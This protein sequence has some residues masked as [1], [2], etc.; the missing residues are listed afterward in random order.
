MCREVECTRK[1]I[2][3]GVGGMREEGE[4]SRL[5]LTCSYDNDVVV[6]VVV[7]VVIVVVAI[8]TSKHANKQAIQTTNRPTQLCT[9]Y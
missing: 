3:K 4:G 6:V 7:V 1:G 5:L 8:Q 2:G 9:V